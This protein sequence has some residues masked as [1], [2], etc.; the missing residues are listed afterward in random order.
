MLSVPGV[1]TVLLL[2]GTNDL[3]GG[4]NAPPAPAAQV[5]DAM[6]TIAARVHAAGGAV[7]GRNIPLNIF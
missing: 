3:G 2:E 1:R 7:L 4:T 6:R 5:I